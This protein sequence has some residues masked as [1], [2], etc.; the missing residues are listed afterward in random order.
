MKKQYNYIKNATV[1]A[2][3]ITVAGLTSCKKV[4]DV[5][6]P[7]TL[8]N[9][10]NIYLSNTT[11]EAVVSGLYANLASTGHMYNGSGSLTIQ[12]GLAADEL[13][14]YSSS[15]AGTT[16][17]YTNALNS[18]NTYYWQEIFSELF[19]CNSAINGL[20]SSTSLTPAIQQQL[21]GD[22]KFARAFI[23]FNAV[24]LYG[25]LPL[26]LST[27]PTVNNVISRSPAATVLNQVIQDLTDAQNLLPDN[28]YVTL[29]N[30]TPTD[31]FLPNKQTASALL[32]RV[33][34]YMKD[35]KN[36]EAQASNVI[37]AS[38]YV[39]EPV[40]TNVFLRTSRETIW[41]IQPT[42]ATTANG[43]AYS[44]IMTGVPNGIVNVYA[45]SPNLLNAFESGDNRF[46]NWIGKIQSDTTTYYFAYKYKQN[47]VTSASGVTEYPVMFRLAEQYLIRAEAR[48][49]QNNLNGAQTDLNAIRT[50][51]GLGNTT[52]VTQT[53]LL[54]AVYHERQIELFLESGHRWFDLK[55][56]GRLD[57]VMSVVSPQ[58]GGAWSP[59]KA[60]IPLPASEISLNSH[61]TQNP[62]Y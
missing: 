15:A 14:D 36:A 28:K 4:I 24:N 22:V 61:L 48:A 3:I 53:D 9:T 55:R 20:T 47:T 56:T 60:L 62:G 51:A 46:T 50:R 37:S 40:L 59:Y 57:A 5:G 38:S 41:D 35:W 45:L 11:A 8:I 54:N 18:N 31:R 43:D 2:C 32:A 7:K 33:Y 12:Q 52:A 39:L 6:E 19:T 23:F 34:L 44:L 16:T 30:G 29:A 13:K 27:D 26:A 49:E 10:A 1:L 21:I 17:F 25:D 42:S 58:K